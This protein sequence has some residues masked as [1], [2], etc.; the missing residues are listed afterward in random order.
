MNFNPGKLAN[1]FLFTVL[2][3]TFCS[4]CIL[5]NYDYELKECHKTPMEAVNVSINDYNRFF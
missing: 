1:S 2:S 4:C 3:M 5:E